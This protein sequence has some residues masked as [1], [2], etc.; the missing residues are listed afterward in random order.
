MVSYI[1]ECMGDY[2]F[3]EIVFFAKKRFVEGFDTIE[4]M[5]AADNQREKEEIALVS[6]LDV[7]N[8]EVR[9]LQLSC[10]HAG[11]CKAMDCRYRLKNMIADQIGKFFKQG[12]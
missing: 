12:E 1:P 5:V 7:A 3:D 2:D 10:K 9:G 4:L 11:Q 6:L 8:D